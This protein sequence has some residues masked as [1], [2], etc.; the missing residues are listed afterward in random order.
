MGL[1]LPWFRR[2][3]ATLLAAEGLAP[4]AQET[5]LDAFQ[6]RFLER[7]PALLDET[8]SFTASSLA[9]RIT[10]SFDLMGGGV[11]IDGGV[12]A[13]GAALMACV[14]QLR[15]GDNELMICIAAHQD[16]SI[17]RFEALSLLGLLDEQTAAA[18]LDRAARGFLPAEGCGVLV[19]RRLADAH[20]AGDPV[21]AVIRGV[22][23]GTDTLPWRAPPAGAPPRAGGGGGRGGRGSSGSALASRRSTPT[24]S[25]GW[26]GPTPRPG[27]G[28]RDH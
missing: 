21:L 27:G 20:A 14:D 13:A 26:P 4:T 8:G 18:P 17:N 12:T 25:R 5:L 9:S 28:P 11:A 19:L 10:K 7:M 6:A 23:S 24:R 15:A 16:M 1:R 22:G 3:L 2:I